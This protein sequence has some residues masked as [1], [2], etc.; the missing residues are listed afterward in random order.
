MNNMKITFLGSGNIARAIINGLIANG[1]PPGDIT[2]ADPMQSARDEAEKLGIN[3]TTDNR[4]AT[5]HA[6]VVIIAV[7]PNVIKTIA[8]EIAS[9][10]GQKLLISVAAGIP[11]QLLRGS[12]G[13]KAH[14]IR[15]MPNTPAQIQSGITGLFATTVI[16]KTEKKI[17]EKILGAVGKYIWVNNETDLHAVTAVSG[18]GPAYFFYIIEAL[19]KAATQVGLDE[20]LARMLVN[21]TAIGAAKMTLTE[22]TKT[23][24]QLRREVTSPGGTTAAAISILEQ[25]DLA[26]LLSQAVESAHARSIE[27]ARDIT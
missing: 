1:T 21:E 3:V 25:G 4:V 18:S 12:L 9:S 15:C 22:T 19:Q 24:E 16:S 7:K 14:I 8:K 2:A 26:G 6:D 5:R 13:S 10:I 20:N 17:A 11:S 27:L 23:A